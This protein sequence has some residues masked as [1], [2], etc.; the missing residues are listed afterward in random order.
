MQLFYPNIQW[1]L[2]QKISF[3]FF[4]LFILLFIF[5][6]PLDTLLFF[7]PK[8]SEAWFSFLD[9]IIPF[10]GRSVL[11]IDH[12]IPME[13]NGSGDKTKNYISLFI[14]FIVSLAFTIV[15]SFFD[16][17]RKS[18][19]TLFHYFLIICRYYLA[20]VLIGYGL[21]KVFKLQMSEISL[22]QLLMPIGD[23]S[24]MGLAWKFIGYSDIYCR[25]SG[26]C[27]VIP[28]IL[29]MFRR[30]TLLGGLISLTV[31]FNVMIMNY[32]YDI[33]VKIYSTFLVVITIVILSPYSTKLFNILLL[34]KKT[35]DAA[36]I[37]PLFAKGLKRTIAYALKAIIIIFLLGSSYSD[38]KEMNTT[39]GEA[40]PKPP[41]YGIYKTEVFIRN[42]DTIPLYS[43]STAW[44]HLVFNKYRN[45]SVYRF[46][47]KRS[48]WNAITDTVQ[49]TIEAK[50][51]NGPSVQFKINYTKINDSIFVFSGIV[52]KDTLKIITK[53]YSRENFNLYNI[54]FNWI[55]EF[56]NNQ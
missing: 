54:K 22:G 12:P 29:L 25:F 35:C 21:H 53:H 44:K 4:F 40:A 42:N 16:R 46:S 3:R 47:D 14:F 31:M 27:E 38:A 41:L 26:W 28:G 30:T 9:S 23:Q 2:F 56:P 5:P 37:K 43:D 55:N 10:F 32:A 18:Y 1:N 15:W 6:F 20:F 45:I 39:W 50:D 13:E 7:I 11:G 48:A 24:P 49:K 34:S 19:D 17:K 51:I 8:I 36:E 52:K 33:P